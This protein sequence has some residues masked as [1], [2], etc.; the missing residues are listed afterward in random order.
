MVVK[1]S[2][3]SRAHAEESSAACKL[4]LGDLKCYITAACHRYSADLPQGSLG[5]PFKLVFSGQEETVA[6][7]RKL[8]PEL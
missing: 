3:C 5:I 1:E 7:I 2:V 4:F 6:K 8:F